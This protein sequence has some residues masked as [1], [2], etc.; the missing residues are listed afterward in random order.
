MSF[1]PATELTT[2]DPQSSK[3]LSLALYVLPAG[4]ALPLFHRGIVS[5]TLFHRGVISATLARL[6]AFLI[7]GAVQKLTGGVQQPLEIAVV[8]ETDKCLRM[9]VPAAPG[10]GGHQMS[11]LH[12]DIQDNAR[13]PAEST[14]H[15]R[16]C[17]VLGC[18][19]PHSVILIFNSLWNSVTSSCLKMTSLVGPIG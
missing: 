2:A 15:V 11:G 1:R 9:G 6:P 17:C 4:N 10:H 18:M 8:C 19:E 3:Y 12:C 5:A 13:V 7:S 14:I 16:R